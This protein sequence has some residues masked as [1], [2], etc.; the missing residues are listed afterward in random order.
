QKV[1]AHKKMKQS[2]ALAPNSIVAGDE[3]D[4]MELLGNLLENAFKYGHQ[5]VRM[6]S[7]LT[8]NQLCIDIEDDGPGV[9][10][11]QTERILERGQRLDTNQPG[12]GIGLAVAA[13]IIR[14][15]DGDIR[16]SRSEL[17]GARFSIFL[18]A[19]ATSD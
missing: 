7:S 15:Y 6:S 19:P 13:E 16:I 5:E 17:G 4:V 1:Y 2:L 8:D 10:E 12:Q 11:D 18:P 14:S 9:P 3:Q